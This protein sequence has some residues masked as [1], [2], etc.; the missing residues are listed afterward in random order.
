MKVSQSP[1]LLISWAN[2]SWLR[3]LSVPCRMFTSLPD[4]Y[5]LMPVTSPVCDSQIFPGI[6]KCVLQRKIAAPSTPS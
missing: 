4:L 5:Y 2:N 6:D 1:A 3:G